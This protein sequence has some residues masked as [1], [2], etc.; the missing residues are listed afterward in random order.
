MR[1]VSKV[2]L[3]WMLGEGRNEMCCIS[4]HD[5]WDGGYDDP[6][7]YE[8]GCCVFIV[9]CGAAQFMGWR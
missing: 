3:C 6:L 8:I 2:Y 4:C 7:E 9:C 1:S 5:D